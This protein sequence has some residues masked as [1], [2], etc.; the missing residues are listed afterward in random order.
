MMKL[1][2]DEDFCC[3]QPMGRKKV[4]DVNSKRSLLVFICDHCNSHFE[5]SESAVLNTEDKLKATS[6]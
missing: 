3:N 2:V 4:I 6:P 5:I 1:E